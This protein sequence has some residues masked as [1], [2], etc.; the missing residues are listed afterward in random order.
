MASIATSSTVDL[1]GAKVFYRQAGPS[2]PGAPTVLLLHGF[3]SSSHQFRNL[4]PLLASKGYRVIAPDLPG[5]GFTTVPDNFVYNFS[6]LTSTIDGF[7]S[8]LGLRKFAIYVFDYGA[9]TGFRLALKHSEDVVAIVSQNGNA[10]E[11]GFGAEF[12]APLRKY[13]AS[14]AK[15]DRDALR[16]L[17]EIGATKWQYTNGSPN[18]DKIQ[19]EAYYLDQTLMD[20]EGNKEIQLDLFYDYGNNIELYPAFHEYF[21]KSK[22][23]VLAIW[24]KNDTTLFR[25]VR[26]SLSEMSK[27]L[28]YASL[29]RAISLWR[30]MSRSLQRRC[31]D[32]LRSSRFSNYLGK[33]SRII[34]ND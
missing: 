13:W 18:P 17:L 24:G 2:D 1:D 4:I 5:F 11:E 25:L 33:H 34:S 12:W 6:S 26:K 22:V 7:I 20:R 28:R 16:G 21:R 32:S 9:P 14:G 10:Y 27:T 8:A 23:P 29:T 31:T 15:E 30:R 3:P 19:P